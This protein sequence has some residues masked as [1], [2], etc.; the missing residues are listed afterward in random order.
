MHRNEDL[1]ALNYCVL[2][3]VFHI[4]AI[5]ESNMFTTT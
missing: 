3:E 5:H 1:G 2:I 4:L